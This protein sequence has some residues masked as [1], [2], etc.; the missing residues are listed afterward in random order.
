MSNHFRPVGYDLLVSSIEFGFNHKLNTTRHVAVVWS[1]TRDA[2]RNKPNHS[3]L[4][5]SKQVQP[6]KI[7]TILS[8]LAMVCSYWKPK[9]EKYSSLPCLNSVASHSL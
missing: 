7:C 1:G 4:Q 8:C 5:T 6:K 9:Y 2:H 3:V